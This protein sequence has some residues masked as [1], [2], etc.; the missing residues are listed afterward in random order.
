MI[1]T[2][3]SSSSSSSYSSTELNDY[4]SQKNSDFKIPMHRKI[5]SAMK[6]RSNLLENITVTSGLP[7]SLSFRKICSRCGR[8]RSEHGEMGF[9]NSCSFEHCG[10]CGAAAHCHQRVGQV[11]GVLCQLSANDGAK[12]GASAIYLR[13]LRDL[14][15]RADLERQTIHRRQSILLL[16]DDNRE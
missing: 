4:H 3:S 14:A 5:G 9:G 2:T 1:P 12:T 15:A 8:T 11:M 16:G 10:R 7:K 13:K 6:E